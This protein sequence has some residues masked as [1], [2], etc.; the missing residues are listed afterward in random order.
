MMDEFDNNCMPMSVAQCSHPSSCGTATAPFPKCNYALREIGQINA[1]LEWRV[2][3][4]T[5]ALAR[6]ETFVQSILDSVSSHIAVIDQAGVIMKINDAW[7]RFSLENGVVPGQMAPHTDVG[8]NY[9]DVC[10]DNIAMSS[11]QDLAAREGILAV[12]AKRLPSFSIEYACHSH[13]QQRWFSMTAT[14]L[15]GNT[16]GAVI[17]HNDITERKQIEEMVRN[18]AYYDSLTQLPNRRMLQERLTLI[19]ASSKRSGLHAALMLV[20]LDNFKPLNDGYG[21]TTGD[22]LLIEVA[23]RLSGS[24]REIDT[25]VRLGGDEFVV[26]LGGLNVDKS[27]SAELALAIAEKIRATLELPYLINMAQENGST[28][29]IE[30]SCSSSIGVTLFAGQDTDRNEILRQADEAMYKAKHA[31]RNS[32][33]FFG[34][35]K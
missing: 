1:D 20:D 2:S 30:H 18:L 35:L 34:S 24:V 9:L 15:G 5:A 29:T 19:L 21:H 14:P 22:R 26:L 10:G 4:R 17:V 25:V 16:N 8:A 32:V 12:L 3:E 13:Q 31:G 23:E 27:V 7:K 33:R 11:E 6:N 28:A